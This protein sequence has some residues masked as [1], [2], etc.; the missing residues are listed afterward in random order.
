MKEENV[1]TAMKRGKAPM[2]AGEG[3]ERALQ[4][5]SSALSLSLP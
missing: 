3:M 5:K 1:T 2:G 4:V